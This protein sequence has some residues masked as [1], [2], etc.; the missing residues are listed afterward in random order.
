[1]SSP[2]TTASPRRRSA[3]FILAEVPDSAVVGEEDGRKRNRSDRLVR[4]S[5]RRHLELRARYRLLVRLGRRGHRRRDRRRCD[6]RSRS[7][8]IV[9]SADLGGA[10]LNGAPIRSRAAAGRA[11][12]DADHRLSGGAR[13]PPR[14]RARR[15]SPAS[16]TLV[17]TF[18]TLRRPGSA[19]LSIAQVAAGWADAA[20]GFG[21]NAWDVTAAILILRQAGGPLPRRCHRARCRGTRPAHLCPGYVAT[22]AGARLS[23]ARPG[24]G[25]HLRPGRIAAR[26]PR[27]F[28]QVRVHPM[29]I[30][31]R[32]A[33]RPPPTS[34]PAPTSAASWRSRPASRA[35]RLRRRAGGYPH[36]GAAGLP[37]RDRRRGGAPRQARPSPRP[38]PATASSARR[39]AAASAATP[40]WSTRST[41][42]PTSPAACRTSASRSPSSATA[43][44]RS[45][46]S[47]TPRST[48]CYFARR[49][50]RRDP[51]RRADPGRADRRLRRRL[52]RTRLV[53]PRAE[54]ALPRGDGRRC[55]TRGA[56]V[57]RGASGALALA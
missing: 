38:F 46:R 23:D 20:C 21:V 31:I 12:G 27:R 14:R 10:W 16:A 3:A 50:A 40:G 25:R 55:S 41:A 51:Q 43:R 19:A 29:N 34:T 37:D 57:R 15:R 24:G 32:P 33:G 44:P 5:D 26:P 39:P 45:A 35:R 4:R 36:E 54:R 56:N 8:A 2:A 17:E 53:D 1:M 28:R 7:A 49:G 18:S 48:S 42:P 11:A 30:D 52:R 6:R 22:G 13:L 47:T 9:F